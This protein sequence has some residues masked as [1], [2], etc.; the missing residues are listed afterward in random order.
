M[1]FHLASQ[2]LFDIFGI[3]FG[4]KFWKTTEYTE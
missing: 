2:G 3:K 1:I 4:I